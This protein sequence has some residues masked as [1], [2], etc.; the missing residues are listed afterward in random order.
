MACD[1]CFVSGGGTFCT[2]MCKIVTIN[3]RTRNSWESIVK[4]GLAAVVALFLVTSCS[5]QHPNGVDQSLY[6]KGYCPSNCEKIHLSQNYNNQ[7]P[8]EQ[9]P[10][11]TK[12]T[13][14]TPPW[15]K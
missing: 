12:Y 10:A 6:C 3:R 2:G 11:N 5:Q 8:V 7:Q 1:K 14:I 4:W 9:L 13:Y 15:E